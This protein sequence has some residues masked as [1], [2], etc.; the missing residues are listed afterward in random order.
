MIKSVTNYNIV[1]LIGNVLIVITLGSIFFYCATYV[2]EKGEVQ[3]TK[4]FNA[5]KMPFFF[6][7][8]VFAIEVMLM[9]FIDFFRQ[10]EY[11]SN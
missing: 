10:L 2:A 9:F 6:G 1:S 11:C 8:A 5:E 7:V 4:L 3:G